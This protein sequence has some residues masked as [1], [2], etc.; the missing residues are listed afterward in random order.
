VRPGRL[1]LVVSATA[2]VVALVWSALVLPDRVPSHFDAAGRV[3][4]WTSRTTMVVFW[5]AMGLAVLVAMPAL[6]RLAA[7]GDGT[8]VNMPQRSKDY[9]FAPERRA[10][11]RVRFGDD[12]EGFA[13]LT[14][15]LMVAV[16]A[17]TTWVATTG[18]DGA[19]WWA[20]VGLMAAYL[21]ATAVWVARLLRAYRPPASP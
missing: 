12:L 20:F 10:E 9:W 7:A 21:A 5:L 15:A 11:F 17:L 16:L 13:A 3:D 2:Y 4:D 19:P 18:R 1:A 14:G 8:W 6:T